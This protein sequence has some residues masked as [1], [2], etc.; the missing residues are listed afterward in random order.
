MEATGVALSL[1][2]VAIQ[3]SSI[4]LAYAKRPRCLRNLVEN[5]VRGLALAYE[6]QRTSVRPGVGQST[7]V[8]V[9]RGG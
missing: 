4:G 6:D 3:S 5:E 1:A 9:V 7:Q 2:W 8:R